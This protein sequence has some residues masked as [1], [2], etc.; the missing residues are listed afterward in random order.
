MRHYQSEKWALKA[1][2]FIARVPA[3]WALACI[4]NVHC[5][6]FRKT[7]GKTI[8]KDK[9]EYNYT[10]TIHGP[11]VPRPGAHGAFAYSR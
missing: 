4:F 10:M 9:N 1:L 3:F 11:E 5:S 8:L 7:Y 2:E 6:I